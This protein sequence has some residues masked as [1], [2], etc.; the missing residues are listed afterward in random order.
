VPGRLA[1]AATE[2]VTVGFDQGEGVLKAVRHYDLIVIGGGLA[3]SGI[4][5]VMANASFRVLV[6][7]KE[8]QFKDR[9][10]GEVL[11]P[12]GS[13]EA[14][15]LG[16]YDV[17]LET[18]ASEAPNERPYADG[19]AMPVRDYRATTPKSTCALFFYHPEM[20]E[21]LLAKAVQDGVEVL[22]GAKVISLRPGDR[23]EIEIAQGDETVVASARLVVAAD[24]RESQIAT[25]LGFERTRDDPELCIGGLQLSGD[26]GIPNDLHFFLHSG[27]G[28]GGI[29][30]RNRPG[31]FRAYILHHKDA[32][33]RRLSGSRDYLEVM[34]NFKEIGIPEEWLSS[35]EPHGLFA[36]FD[37]AH[38]WIAAPVRDNVVLIGDAASA[39]DPVWGNGLSRTLRDVRLLRDRLLSDSD[40]SRAAQAYGV[41][42]DDAFMR[43]RR[44]ERLNARLHFAIGAEADKRRERAYAMMEANRTLSPD[45]TGMG[46]DARCDDEV[47]AALLGDARL[48]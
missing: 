5:S 29:L 39:S 46:P 16:I 1:V 33:P 27:N 14:I 3:G 45:M 43:L 25:L 48:A 44:I 13:A 21:A 10:R 8:N 36:T 35:L 34:R 6:V 24:G 19:V 32:L 22:R 42:H 7:E 31:N 30:L 18:C 26:T 2:A 40:W 23:P 28:R 15:E 41:D 17:L 12:W 37:G 47:V 9:I 38:R 20:Q 4:A 11:L